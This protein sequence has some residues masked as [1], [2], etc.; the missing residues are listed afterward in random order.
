MENSQAVESTKME[1]IKEDSEEEVEKNEEVEEVQ[2][3]PFGVFGITFLINL[4]QYAVFL[5]F[6]MLVLMLIRIFGP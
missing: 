5:G 3:V 4:L 1:P 2:P 6:S